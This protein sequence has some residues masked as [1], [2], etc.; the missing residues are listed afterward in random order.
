MWYLHALDGSC[1]VTTIKHVWSFLGQR[2]IR[3][4]TWM[5]MYKWNGGCPLVSIVVLFMMTS[6]NGD[7]FRVTGL[8]C[9]EFTHPRWFLSQRLVARSFDVFFDLCLNKRLSKQSK[10]RWSGTPASSLWCHC[11]QLV[12]IVVLL[13]WYRGILIATHLKIGYP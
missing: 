6:S 11:Y 1:V 12:S 4:H 5:H 9:G 7:I 3:E 10:R 2:Q 8:L 13:S